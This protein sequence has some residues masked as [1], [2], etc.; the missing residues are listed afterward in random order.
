MTEPLKVLSATD[1]NAFGDCL[2]PGIMKASTVLDLDPAQTWLILMAYCGLIARDMQMPDDYFR[3]GV[4]LA[5]RV[6]ETETP[7]RTLQ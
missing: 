4:D 7:Q 6:R 5:K 3:R 1:M 2:L